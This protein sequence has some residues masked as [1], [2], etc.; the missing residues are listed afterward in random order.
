MKDRKEVILKWFTHK[1]DKTGEV[2][3]ATEEATR[4][5]L[6][7]LKDYANVQESLPSEGLLVLRNLEEWV[8]E[9]YIRQLYEPLGQIVSIKLRKIALNEKDNSQL[10]RYHMSQAITSDAYTLGPISTTCREIG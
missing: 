8:D 7:E 3:F 1:T 4:K 10:L 2:V 5:G 6:E 9:D